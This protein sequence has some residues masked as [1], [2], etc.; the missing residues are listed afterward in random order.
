MRKLYVFNPGH[1]LAL[2][3]GSASYMMP[4]S[5]RRFANDLAFLPAWYAQRA[6]VLVP[7]GFRF[8]TPMP[9]SAQ[10]VTVDRIYQKHYDAIVP[11]GWNEALCKQLV[12]IGIPQ[13]ILYPKEQLQAI[14]LLAHRNLARQ[15]MLFLQEKHPNRLLPEPAQLLENNEEVQAYAARHARSVFKAPWSGSGKGIFFAKPPL[16]ASLLAWCRRTIFKQGGDLAEEAV[17]KI[18]DVAM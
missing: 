18:Q 14:R 2:A 9:L 5:A 15:A 6:D 16:T 12:D 10:Y 8:Y 3:N 17:E 7:K 11:W 13:E 1:D 4:D